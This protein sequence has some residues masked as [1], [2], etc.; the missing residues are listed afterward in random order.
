VLA[1]VAAA[2]ELPQVS[3][4]EEAGLAASCLLALPGAS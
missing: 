2:R 1:A 3:L 4:V